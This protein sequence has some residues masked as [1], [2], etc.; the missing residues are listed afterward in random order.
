MRTDNYETKRE[1]IE[2]VQLTP[3]N[4]L[5]VARWTG[6]KIVNDVLEMYVESGT[7]IVG[8]TDYVCRDT[9]TGQFF[10]MHPDKFEAKYHKTGVRSDLAREFYGEGQNGGS[11]VPVLQQVFNSGLINQDLLSRLA[12]AVLEGKWGNGERRKQLLGTHYEA[13]Q[14]EVNRRVASRHQGQPINRSGALRV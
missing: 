7:I 14:A 6:G 11:P 10:A 2:S 5:E 9:E 3:A 13:V 1:R 8:Y 12:D 4:E